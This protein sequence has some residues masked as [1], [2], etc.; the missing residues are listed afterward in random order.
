MNESFV[1]KYTNGNSRLTLNPLPNLKLLLNWF[2]DL[3]AKNVKILML[4]KFKR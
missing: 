4:M 2:I 1:E 3:T